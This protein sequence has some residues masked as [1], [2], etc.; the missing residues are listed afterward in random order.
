M[1]EY[2]HLDRVMGYG[3]IQTLHKNL[4]LKSLNIQKTGFHNTAKFDVSEDIKNTIL[5]GNGVE[6]FWRILHFS[7]QWYTNFR[8]L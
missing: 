7:E 8:T 3:S 1:Q 6:V 5:I 2:T 4:S